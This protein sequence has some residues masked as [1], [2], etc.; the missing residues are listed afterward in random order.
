[1]PIKPEKG[2]HENRHEKRFSRGCCFF[3]HPWFVVLACWKLCG[4]PLAAFSNSTPTN[5]PLGATV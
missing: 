1:M 5:L 4:F 3:L 2:F